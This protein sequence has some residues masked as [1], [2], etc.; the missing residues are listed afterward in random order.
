MSGVKKK[1]KYNHLLIVLC[2][3]LCVLAYGIQRLFG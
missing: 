1:L 3:G 2:L